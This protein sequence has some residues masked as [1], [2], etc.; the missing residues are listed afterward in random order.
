MTTII[1]MW[2]GPRNI[3]TTMMRAFENRADATAIDEP[4]YAS[5]LA[6][7][8]ADHPYREET[9]AAQ[10]TKFGEVVKWIETQPADGSSVLFLKH[11][12]FHLPD[13]AD[14]QFIHRH[15]NFL[16]IRDP[17]AM[18]A[19]YAKKFEDVSPIVKSY[20]IERRI[21][22]ELTA[23]G[24]PCPVVDAADVLAAPE[25]VLRKLCAGLGL[26]FDPSMLSWPAGRRDCD[27]VWAPHWYDAVW[28]STGFNSPVEKPVELSATLETV[29][30][31]CMANYRFLH[32]KRLTA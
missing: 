11:I 2:S 7:S 26:E 27:G 12:A 17:R 10:P 31:E 19:S 18:V 21:L 32:S 28:A 8:G 29:A 13:G 9:L 25:A 14:L 5:Y 20:E 30:D 3:S 23:H 16:L 6:R 15:R 4:F 22:D 1:S 24:L